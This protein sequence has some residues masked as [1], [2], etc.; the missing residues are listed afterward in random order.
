VAARCHH[1]GSGNSGCRRPGN[2]ADVHVPEVIPIARETGYHT[3]TIGRYADGQFYAR[4][5]GAHRD[6]DR[7][8]N[9]DR[10][11]IRWY[12]YV[13]LFGLDGVHVRSDVALIGIGPYLRGQLGE[14]ADATLAALLDQL[15]DRTFGG[16]AIRPFRVLY[17][18]VT[19]GLIDESDTDRGAW[20]ELYPDRLGFGEPWDGLYDT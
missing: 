14:Q 11:R 7:E 6:D 1:A 4:I 18:G 12:A 8:H 13:H 15:P 19:F 5:H 9:L 20:F 16:I 3:D 10:E 2:L 17:D